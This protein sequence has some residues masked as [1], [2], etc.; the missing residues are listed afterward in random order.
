M[1]KLLFIL[2]L[3]VPFLGFGQSM[4]IK[5]EDQDGREFSIN[6]VTG[7][8][9]YSMV[10]GDK[11]SYITQSWKGPVGSVESIGP[12]D[13]E[14]ITQSWKGPVGSVESVGSVDIEYITQSWKGPVGYIESVGGL[15][16]N[17]IT[18]SWKGPV[19]SVES[20]SGRVN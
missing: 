20:T 6:N 1:K 13:I 9:K 7:D 8:L 15:T 10:S 14:Y 16:I 2:L 17:Y 4:N 18:Q 3:T 11:I 5:W 12:V 19:G